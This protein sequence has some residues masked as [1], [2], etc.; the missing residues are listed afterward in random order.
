MDWTFWVSILA[1]VMLSDSVSGSEQPKPIKLTVE[2]WDGEVTLLWEPPKG[3]P[4]P[5]QYQVQIE[6]YGQP[7]WIN[8]TSC[9]NTQLTHCDLTRHIHNYIYLY[10]ARI[11]LITQNGT[12]PWSAVKRF[13]PKNTKLRFP[14][15][16]LLTTSTSV[17]VQVQQKPLLK[18]I[19]SY[20]LSYTVY[21]KLENETTIRTLTVDRDEGEAEVQFTSLRSGKKYCVSLKAEGIGGLSSSKLSPEN[22][23]FLPEQEWFIIALVSTSILTL[24]VLALFIFFFLRRP[25][26]MP[27]SLKSLNS[28]WQPFSL[29]EDAFEVV[30][31]NGWFFS[32]TT[33]DTGVWV[34]ND[35]TG[36][37]V[38][39]KEAT[40]GRK[41]SLDSGVS[42]K[43][44]F[45]G[46]ENDDGSARPEDSGCGSL[47]APESVVSSSS[48]T[49]ESP[50]LNGRTYRDTGR[51]E[52]SGMGLGCQSDSAVSLQGEDRGGD[53]G[54]AA[55]DCYRGQSPVSADDHVAE[56]EPE[57][58]TGGSAP[59]YRSGHLAC[60]CFGTGRCLWC[61]AERQYMMRDAGQFET[62]ACSSYPEEQLI[63][64]H[65]SGDLYDPCY[66]LNTLEIETV[67]LLEDS[68]DMAP[69][70]ACMGGSFP[71]LAALSEA[72]VAHGGLDWAVKTIPI[73]LGDLRVTLD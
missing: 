40:A 49:E 70:L 21:L 4:S 57:K 39:A 2:I 56:A 44:Q 28:G 14:S 13:N 27:L 15:S 33:T 11:R 45:S 12:S 3:D 65:L 5:A 7:E 50:L 53:T 1:H 32:S 18:R 69:L 20:G 72:P 51:T 26:K 48:G 22:C 63:C 54:S 60:I 19:F 35:R 64:S 41:M 62:V 66:K 61:Q 25:R 67:G 17:T 34:A 16:T 31:D 6:R 58:E 55:P 46:T 9:E 38:T 73:S 37:V 43:T 52:D 30:T 23:F 36:S 47:G 8:V 24:F 10:K 42:S 71:L 59:G 68:V 29:A